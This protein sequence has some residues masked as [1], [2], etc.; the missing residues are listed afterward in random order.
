MPLSHSHPSIYRADHEL[1]DL[2]V[3][4]NDGKNWKSQVS[5][6]WRLPENVVEPSSWCPN[7]WHKYPDMVSSF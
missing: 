2:E 3:T 1:L 5:V 7:V 4:E 6:P